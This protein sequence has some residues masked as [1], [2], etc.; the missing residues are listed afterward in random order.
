M[1]KNYDLHGI[2]PV[3]HL[4]RQDHPVKYY[5]IDFGISSLFEPDE[6]PLAV[7]TKGRDKEPPELSD[8]EPYNPFYLDIFVLGNLY[9]QEFVQ[10]NASLI[11]LI[12]V[13]HSI[14]VEVP[15]TRFSAPVNR[16]DASARPILAAKCSSC[17]VY[18]PD[19]SI[20]S[21]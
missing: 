18:I 5:F 16:S 8:T 12:A 4:N 20:R 7:G 1:R 9:L 21:K 2:Y 15:R 19:Y 6:V 10:V 14:F 17:L 13:T 3:P 11:F